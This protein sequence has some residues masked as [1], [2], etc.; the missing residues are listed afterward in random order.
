MPRG[1]VT[2]DGIDE[3]FA[4]QY[5]LQECEEYGYGPR[6]KLNAINSDGTIRLAKTFSSPGERRTLI[7]LVQA[8]KPYWDIKMCGHNNPGLVPVRATAEW[9]IQYNIK[10]LNIAGNSE[11]TAKGIY[12]FAYD[13]LVELFTYMKGL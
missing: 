8:D 13:Y 12:R 6:T 9:L 7:E 1:F 5:G 10:T 3:D 11:Q 2:L 4:K